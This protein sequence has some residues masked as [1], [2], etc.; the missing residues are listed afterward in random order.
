MLALY[1]MC[2][3]TLDV[4]FDGQDGSYDGVASTFSDL[5]QTCLQLSPSSVVDEMKRL[6]DSGCE[7]NADGVGEEAVQ[8]H[9]ADGCTDSRPELCALVIDGA[10]TCQDDF[11]QDKKAC[12]HSGACDATCSFCRRRSQ[13]NFGDKCSA[14]TLQSRVEPINAACCDEDGA[15]NGAG[16]GVPTVC[17]AKCAIVYRPFFSDCQTTLQMAFGAHADTY[18]AFLQLASTCDALPVDQLLQATA[19][20]I[21]PNAEPAAQPESGGF[22]NWLDAALDCPLGMLEHY[23]INID[24]QCCADDPDN[25]FWP[26]GGSPAECSLDCGTAMLGSATQCTKTMDVVLDGMDGDRDGK[27]HVVDN[28]VG[29]HCLESVCL[30]CVRTADSSSLTPVCLVLASQHQKCMA[31][32]PRAVILHL[33]ELQ[34]QGCPIDVNGVSE[35][36]VGADG[37]GACV[38][39]ADSALCSL[40]TSG[41]V[42]CSVDFC[43]GACPHASACDAT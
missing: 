36:T 11:C 20:A 39:T 4:L 41:L 12:A 16:A 6:Q 10:L 1:S 24:N 25:C 43:P 35:T 38:D 26:E 27:S 23:A 30:C 3:Q 22:G 31:I 13:I 21:C 19:G 15:C 32:P 8:Q 7:V 14:L 34:D 29:F 37:G 18:A 42:S 2:N 5:R 9:G 17:D 28:L 33:K 40:V